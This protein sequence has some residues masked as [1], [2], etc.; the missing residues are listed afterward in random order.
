MADAP[1]A[2][3]R[4]L[5]AAS[6]PAARDASWSDFVS[7]YSKLIL[8]VARSAGGDQ[9]SAMDRYAYILEQLQC[10][11]F[12]RLRTYVADGRSAFST[13]LVV[14]TQRM[15]LDHR[16]HRY[17]RLR[18]AE[19]PT[20]AHDE[21]WRARRRLV[22]MI[23]AEI[24]LDSLPDHH[25]GADSESDVRLADIHRALASALAVLEPRDR[26]L[27]KLRFEDGLPM[28]EIAEHLRLPTRFHAYRR[29]TEV[30]GILRRTLERGGI[31]EATP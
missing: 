16:R 25:G 30:L 18:S 14:V 3:L 5:L 12:R 7:G 31:G 6:D 21:E 19:E 15:C 4:R 26:L 11:D 22:D 17:G 13:W 20:G 2:V 8:H 24:D 28:P 9:D 29:L 1:P 10:E 23:S 27:I